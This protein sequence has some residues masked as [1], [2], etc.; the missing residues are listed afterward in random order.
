MMKRTGKTDY[1]SG[2]GYQAVDLDYKFSDMSMTILLPDAGN[3][4]AF[5]SSLDEELVWTDS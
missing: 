2:D 4:E 1:A 3:F 5:E